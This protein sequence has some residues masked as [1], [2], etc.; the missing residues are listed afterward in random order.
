MLDGGIESW[1]SSERFRAGAEFHETLVASSGNRFFFDALRHIN[2]LRRIIEYR[3]QT[4]SARD[5]ARLYRQCEE[6]LLLLEMIE[7]GSRVEAAR[8]LREHLD[9]VGALKTGAAPRG[10]PSGGKRAASIEVH[11]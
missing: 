7:S 10:A 3:Q 6:H 11:L 5:H 1:S 9:V 2:Q 8:R 4:H